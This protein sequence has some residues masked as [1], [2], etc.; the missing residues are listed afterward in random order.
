MKSS[1]D[2]MT[3]VVN[4]VRNDLL[5]RNNYYQTLALSS[6][7]NI[8]GAEFASALTVDVQKTL[9]AKYTDS[10]VKKKAALCLLKLFRHNPESIVHED[11]APCM[12][13]LLEDNNVHLGVILSVMALLIALATKSAADYEV[14]LPFVIHI[15]SRL[16]LTPRVVREDWLYYL[17]PSPWLQ[18][19]F[20]KFLQLYP[21]PTKP[22]QADRLNE[23]L[24]RVLQ[25]TAVS[26]TVNKSNGD[27]SI[28]FEAV[29]LILAYGNA[30]ESSLKTE[31]MSLLGRFISVQ[32][33]NIR[34]F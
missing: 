9:T 7:A 19:K 6:V 24:K 13:K 5:S 21:P 10:I 22:T 11:W 14:C 16:V 8:G 34:Y 28:L 3:L 29:N 26:E 1:D 2:K 25:N 20:L 18:V 4:S 27:H 31:A 33:P 32:E 15:F 30:A 17:T 23:I 12:V